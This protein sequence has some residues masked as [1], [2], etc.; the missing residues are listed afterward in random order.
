MRTDALRTIAL[1]TSPEAARSVTA[2]AAA[3]LLA[4]RSSRRRGSGHL[5]RLRMRRGDTL[6]HRWLEPLADARRAV[7]GAGA[8]APPRFLIRLDE[9]PQYQARDDPDRFGTGLS[10]SFHRVLAAEGVPYL[11][12]VVPRPAARPL[13]PSGDVATPLSGDERRFL[14]ELRADGVTFAMHGLTHRTRLASPRR[15]SELD[16]LEGE[17]VTTLLDE[18]ERE[19]DALAVAAR[20]F[21][22]PYNRFE[23]SQYPILARRFAVV[24]GG[25]ESALRMG[26]GP[27]PAW[28]GDAVYMPAYH[29]LYGTA[30]QVVPLARE[31]IERRP[32]TWVP[33][34]L[35]TGWE[36]YDEFAGLEALARLV[37]P[38]AA[39]WSDFLDAVDA[40]RTL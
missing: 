22:P 29:P 31:L 19:L 10:R 36:T 40:S 16:G 14:D 4:R 2:A 6:L 35:H 30:R 33:I 25:P 5:D 24:C 26:V 21:V 17:A 23:A 15:R 37:A 7:L 32:G 20:V 39:D 3:E 12:A 9:F 8:A 28:R 13:D 11:V 27:T 38:Y 18:A 34:V 1:H